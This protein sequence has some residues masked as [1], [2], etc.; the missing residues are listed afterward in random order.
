V[1]DGG[2]TAERKAA[3]RSRW[4]LGQRAAAPVSRIPR[5]GWTFLATVIYTVL[6]VQLTWPV[7]TDLDGTI[8][9]AFGD[10][11]GAMAYLRELVDGHHNPFLPGTIDTWAAPDGREID[12]PQNVATFGATATLYVL[13]VPFGAIEAYSIFTIAGYVATGAVTFAFLRKLTGNAWIALLGGWA[14][15]F[16]P[17]AVMKGA[18][19]V[20]FVHQWV[21]VLVLWRM[22]SVYERPTLRNGLIAGA[23]TVLAMSFSAYHL[24]FVGLEWGAL[25]AVGLALP[26]L[27]RTGEFRRQL[28]AQAAGA[29]VVL[30]FAAA[31]SMA[32]SFSAE[33]TGIEGHTLQALTTYAARPLEYLVPHASQPFWGD[34]AA[35]WRTDHLHGSN[36][37][38]TMLYVGW[39]LVLLS[40]VA[41]VAAARRRLE[42]PVFRVVIAATVMG[43]VAL[44]VSAPPE[45]TAFGHLIPFPSKLTYAIGPEWRVYSRLVMVVMLSVVVLGAIGLQRLVQGRSHAVR[46]LVLVAVTAIVVIDL[47]AEPQPPTKLGERPGLERL[48]QLPDGIVANYPIEPAGSGDYSAEFNQGIQEHPILNG[49]KDGSMAEYRALELDDL[50]DPRTPGHLAALG[51]RYVLI[52]HVPVDAGVQ[53]PG[54]PGRGLHLIVDDGFESV[55]RVTA[56]PRPLATFGAGFSPLER[57]EKREFR[58]LAAEQGEIELLGGCAVCRGTLTVEIESF[59]RPRQ[60]SLV[61]EDGTVLSTRTAPANRRA[62]IAFP[63]EFRHRETVLVR[64]TP[65]P[66]PESTLPSARVVSVSI[67]RPRLELR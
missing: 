5:P 18:G 36:F 62:Q 37:S 24:L 3:T 19:H 14:Y 11:T 6:A 25:A 39:S 26:L 2:A 4:A 13:A 57:P 40:L 56:K 46:V 60:V 20:N 50:E 28:R 65:G 30:V 23:V 53:D 29:A 38:E 66:A 35:E 51:V 1:T 55:W 10:L 16:S 32:A 27:Q 33:G 63:V 44:L 58:W 67:T 17:F 49:Y 43:A 61:R 9:G 59:L 47:R 22:I 48:A 15:A 7:V 54:R 41:L 42:P 45:V 34:E 8:F 31:L 52:E 12:W 64:T 21:F